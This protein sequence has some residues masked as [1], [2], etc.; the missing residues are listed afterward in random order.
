MNSNRLIALVGGLAIGLAGF[1]YAESTPSQAAMQ[2]ELTALKARLAELEAK[3]SDTW[4][5]ERRAEEVKGLVRE[6]LSDA[7]TRA[8]LL[9]SGQ[10]AGHDG[11]R[12]F[13]ASEDGSF[14]LKIGSQVQFRYAYNSRNLEGTTTDENEFGFALHRVKL[15]FDGHIGSP[16]ITYSIGLQVEKTDQDVLLNHAFFGYQLMDGVHIYLGE[17][18]G[19]LLREELTSSK[20][21]LAVERSAMNEVFTLGRVQGI[22]LKF[23][24]DDNTKV[25]VSINDGTNTGE[26]ES[27]DKKFSGDETDIALSARIDIRLAGQWSQMKDFSAWSGEE[28][29]V[30]VGGAVH[31][32]I[33]ETGG[34][35]VTIP[36]A[37][38]TTTPADEFFVWTL[39]GSIE[40]EG[41][42]LFGAIVG[43][44]FNNIMGVNDIDEFGFVV[45]GG[46]M[47]I[48]DKSEFFARWEWV[49]PDVSHSVNIIT[50]GNNFYMQKH[51]AKITTDVV[52][53][54]NSLRDLGG[55]SS[56]NLLGSTMD[57][58]NQVAFRAQFQ[59]VY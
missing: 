46:I 8:S 36:T 15:F 55:S 34:G 32:E 51:N 41:A 56:L 33:A 14:L 37:T 47:F 18:K 28:T 59:L 2:S 58:R 1:A 16:R 54:L 12:F 21:Q 10:V 22:W 49:D 6:V 20:Y 45:Q 4:L 11:K 9:A 57:L 38:S 50:V 53:V 40:S 5:N 52:W 30:F 42:N 27:Q 29:A 39:D 7:D 31:Y 43:R 35:T 13:L 25:T 26:A 17:D 23:D 48:P 3:Q 24:T 44:H 19:P